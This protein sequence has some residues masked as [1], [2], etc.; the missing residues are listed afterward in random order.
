VITV[1]STW[2]CKCGVRIM[3]VA[4]RHLDKATAIV[5]VACPECGDERNIDADRIISITH[6]KGD[7]RLSFRASNPG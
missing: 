7:D 5:T 4:E 6:E 1:V 2:H 3:I